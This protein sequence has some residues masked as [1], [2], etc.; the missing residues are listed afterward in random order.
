MGQTLLIV[1]VAIA[2]LACPLHMWWMTRRGKQPA[3][4]GPR[5]DESARD[6]A[7]LRARRQEI[8][9]QL[10]EFEVGGEPERS[11]PTRVER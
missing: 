8:D 10:A 2:V 4:A 9:A 5:K 1:L 3:C 6:L 7:A 11:A